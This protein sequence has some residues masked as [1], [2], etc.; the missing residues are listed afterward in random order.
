MAGEIIRQDDKT[1]HGGTVIEGCA[2]DTC[3]GKPIAYLGHKTSCP[4][5]KGIYPIVEGAP[6]TTLYGEGVA[7]A[8]MKKG[9]RRG[10][11]RRPVYRY[12]RVA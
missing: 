9:V 4:Q 12:G 11:D 7:R 2:V 1:S 8:G 3:D 5:C 10:A 6:V